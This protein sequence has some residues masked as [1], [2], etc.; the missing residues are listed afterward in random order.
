V[1]YFDFE[2]LG[3]KLLSALVYP[4]ELIP[5]DGEPLINPQELKVMVLLKV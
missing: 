1:V 5:S 2:T 3:I 4:A